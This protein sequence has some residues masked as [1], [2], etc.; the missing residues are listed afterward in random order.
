LSLQPPR[1]AARPTE[2]P[3]R[4]SLPALATAL[5]APG[6]CFADPAPASAP[7]ASDLVIADALAPLVVNATQLPTYEEDVPDIRVID[8][9]Q[10]DQRQAVYAADILDTEPGLALTRDGAF[11][12]VTSLRM[13]GASSDK[14]LVLIDGVPQNDPS[15]PNGAY[16]FANLDLS[17]I[18]RIEILQ[19]PQSS[20][21]GSDAIGG[22]VSLTT[23]ELNG[24]QGA[25][26]GGTLN[27]FDGSA[28]VGQKTDTYAFG[29]QLFGDRSDGV[30]KADGIGPRDPY[31]S[32]SAGAYGRLTPT[33][34]ITLDAHLRYEQSY[35]AVDGY[36]AATFVFGYTPQYATTKGWTGDVRAVAQ[37]PLGFTDTVSVGLYQQDRSDIYIGS[38]A[39]SSAYTAMTED[40]RFTAERGAPSDKVGLVVGAERLSTD[41]SLSTGAHEDLGTTS[42]FAVVRYKPID[43]VTLT[44]AGR[45]DAPDTYQSQATGHFSAVWRLPAGFSVEGAWGQGFKTPTISEI[46]CDFCFPTGPST[47]L[48]PEHAVGWDAALAWTSPDQRLRA[49]ITAYRLAVRD[50]IEFSPSFPFRYVNLDN[51]RTDG[52]EAEVDLRLT[53]SLTAHAEYAYTNAT[54]LEA[55]TQML[56]VPRNAG[57]VSLDWTHHRWQADFTLRSEGKDADEDPSTFLPATRPGFTL[58]T[59]SGSYALSPNLQLTARV[60]DIADTHYQEVLGYGEPKRML[61]FGIRAKE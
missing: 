50:Q 57:S 61:W 6:L 40:Y 16:D 59:V 27:S 19:G 15:D 56:R 18:E 53:Q 49:K 58:A 10:I 42:G 23:R 30:A 7:A 21:W 29:A 33:D 37:A 32:W 11:G 12:G 13:R 1:R 4:H 28:A 52:A 26:E 45:Y 44:A 17:N 47:G 38:A 22:V 54:D 5:A 31:W 41:A 46:A 36:D 39:N 43:T 24:W 2:N 55:G 14:T 51:T 48:K 20:L 3:L 34:W 9:Q 25:S 60:E 8:R 35:A